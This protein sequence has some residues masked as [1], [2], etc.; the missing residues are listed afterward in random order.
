MENNEISVNE[1]GK[2]R[3]FIFTVIV[4]LSSVCYG[5]VM[6][7]QSPAVLQLQDAK[8]PAVGG[9]PM[10]DEGV[11][12]MNGILTL[13]ATFMT[14]LLAVIPDKFSRKRFGY[15]LALPTMLSWLLI[16]F[17]TEHIHIYIAKAL[18][19]ITGASVCFL[20]PTYVSEISC[21]SIRGILASSI[22]FCAN[23]GILLAYILGGMMSLYNLAVVGAILTA[24]YI[25]AFAFM[26][27]SPVYLV[28]QNRTREAVRSLNWLKAGDTVIVEQTLS[29]LQLQIKETACTKAAKLSD[30]FRDRATIKGLI[31]VLGLFG[32][33]QFAGIF[34]V[35]SYT[36]SIFK[37]SGSSLSPNMSS[38]IV[39]VIMLLGA[40]LSTSLI[41]RAG[42]RSLLLISCA[43]M[44]MCHCV[45]G[46]FCYLQQLQYD[47]SVY[48]WIPI[49]ALSLFVITYALGMGS[50]PIVI[51][52]EIFSRDVAS[53][54]ATVGFTMAWISAFVLVKIFADLIALLGM[55][56]CFFLLAISCACSFMFCFVLVPETKGRTREDIVEELNGRGQ[57]KEKKNVKQAAIV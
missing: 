39:G 57:Y 48:G 34:A 51:M 23:F 30:L 44:C 20:V 49:A 40:F 10:S 11:S 27:E 54:A 43:A 52:S 53:V 41:E 7:W 14:M 45:I 17:A 21:D 47:V 9:E 50:G 26:P 3:Q 16:M 36:E 37:M 42:R 32:G 46:T 8:S 12:W 4:N 55:H 22:G 25:I 28:R 13:T 5:F 33:Q 19:G 31:I 38:I 24:L 6:G 35:I 18:G 15:A 56:G 29:D 1:P 2:L